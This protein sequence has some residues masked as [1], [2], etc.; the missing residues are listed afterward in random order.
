MKLPKGRNRSEALVESFAYITPLVLDF[1][2]EKYVL[3][4]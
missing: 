3:E 4:F 1:Q 2:K